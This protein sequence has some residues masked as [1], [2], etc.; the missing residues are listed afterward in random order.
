MA[1]YKLE[2]SSNGVFWVNGCSTGRVRRGLT[3][4]K[5]QGKE[6]QIDPLSPRLWC[7]QLR[8]LKISPYVQGRIP[9]GKW[10]GEEVGGGG[11]VRTRDTASSYK[12]PTVPESHSLSLDW[13]D[14]SMHVSEEMVRSREKKR[15][16]QDLVQRG[17]HDKP[18]REVSGLFLISTPC[19]DPS[20][21]SYL[22]LPPFFWPGLPFLCLCCSYSLLH[23]FSFGVRRISKPCCANLEACSRISLA[24]EIRRHASSRWSSCS[25]H[26][27][28]INCGEMRLAC[29]VVPLHG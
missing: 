29:R 9:G 21:L 18:N 16:E 12:E 4:G 5:S 19:L 2:C 23:F 17:S 20:N 25:C 7:G 26:N 24:S 8:L 13:Q 11:G 10:K 28:T 27:P 14:K 15:Q 3:R 22:F 1:P 6:Q